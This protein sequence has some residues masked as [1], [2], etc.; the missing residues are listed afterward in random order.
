MNRLRAFEHNILKTSIFIFERS[1]YV[2][3]KLSTTSFLKVYL[4][5]LISFSLI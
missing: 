3:D 4:W 5:H 2:T 1:M